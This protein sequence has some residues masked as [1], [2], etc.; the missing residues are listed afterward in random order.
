MYDLST[1]KETQITTSG[2]AHDPVIYGDKIV[3]WVSE[4]N[5]NSD[6]YM[7]TISS[8]ETEPKLPIFP[9]C[10]NPPI[11]LNKDGLYEDINGNGIMDFD[12]IVA[13]YDNMDWI[14]KNASVAFFDYNKNGLIDF[15]DIVKLYDVL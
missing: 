13:Y 8:G 3:W 14:E 9:G 10:N 12:D 4:R 5:G 11:D 7:C 1:Q 15:D 2:S 6:I